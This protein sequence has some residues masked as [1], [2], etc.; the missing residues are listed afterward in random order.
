MKNYFPWAVGLFIVSFLLPVMSN[1][2]NP[3]ISIYGWEILMNIFTPSSEGMF[4]DNYF[5][6]F[7]YVL[8][9]LPNILVILIILLKVKKIEQQ[10]WIYWIGMI[11]VF[12]A[13][14]WIPFFFSVLFTDF[15]L[16]YWIWLISLFLIHYYANNGSFKR[17]AK[18]G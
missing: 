7:G 10:K 15:K 14:V 1:Q 16:G 2:F 4:N 3:D 5:Q 18:K 17:P 9:C 11:A 6:V 8:A 12:S 13:L